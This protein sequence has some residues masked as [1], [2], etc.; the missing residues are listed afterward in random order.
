LTGLVGLVSAAIGYHM[1]HS[2]VAWGVVTTNPWYAAF[3]F[4]WGL[5]LAY[6]GASQW[7]GRCVGNFLTALLL[8]LY[9]GAE[10]NG[11]FI[12][13]LPFYANTT[14]LTA[15]ERMASLRPQVL[16]TPT[17][18][19]ASAASLILLGALVCSIKS[20]LLC[21]TGVRESG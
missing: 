10:V 14:G 7:P 8:V 21:R 13:M 17:L 18:Y 2:Q 20:S 16:G 11:T 5:T 4:P 6:V 19:L 12:R 3:A 15:L 9:L 1:V